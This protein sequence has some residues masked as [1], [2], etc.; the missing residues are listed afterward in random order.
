M[1]IVNFVL[2]YFDISNCRISHC[3]PLKRILKNS[4][5]VGFAIVYALTILDRVKNW[6]SSKTKVLITMDHI[7][8]LGINLG[9]GMSAN[10]AF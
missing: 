7:R 5:N 3:N 4:C 8:Y 1:G 10:F 6:P 9:G 2:G